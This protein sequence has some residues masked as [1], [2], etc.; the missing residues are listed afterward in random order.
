MRKVI[1][2][3][4]INT[5]DRVV[6]TTE[7]KQGALVIPV[8]T[9]ATCREYLTPETII[10][11]HNFK[12]EEPQYIG[13]PLDYV[14]PVTAEDL[15]TVDDYKRLVPKIYH[16]GN[17]YIVKRL[18][19]E[20]LTGKIVGVRLAANEMDDVFTM[21][22]HVSS[23]VGEASIT[24]DIS[25]SEIDRIGSFIPFDLPEETSIAEAKEPDKTIE[26]SDDIIRIIIDG[27]EFS[28]IEGNLIIP[29]VDLKDIDKVVQSL[30]KLKRLLG[31]E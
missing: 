29:S 12:D 18:I 15:D 13:L 10:V 16:V 21:N 2:M 8:G 7:Y 14:R 27:I 3:A 26:N 1:A 25:R 11:Q 17:K 30:N 6:V 24:E 22:F 28:I 4:G 31:K 19:G 5:F 9:V 20:P 23:L